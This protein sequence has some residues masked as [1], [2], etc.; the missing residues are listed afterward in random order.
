MSVPP[1]ALL[2]AATVAEMADVILQSQAGK[3]E[4]SAVDRMLA[5]LKA[6]SAQD[7]R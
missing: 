2:A 4:P 7:E 5:D 6:R 3:L 1:Q